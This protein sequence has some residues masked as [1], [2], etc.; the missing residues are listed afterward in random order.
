MSKVVLMKYLERMTAVR[1]ALFEG[2]VVSEETEL[3]GITWGKHPIIFV[4]MKNIEENGELLGTH[5]SR[6]VPFC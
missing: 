4:T 1:T 6:N 5:I 3:W 2:L